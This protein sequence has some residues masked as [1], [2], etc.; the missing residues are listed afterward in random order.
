MD[1]RTHRHDCMALLALLSA[2]IY[3]TSTGPVEKKIDLKIVNN[4]LST[5]FN[6]CFGC[7]KEPSRGDGS[8]EYPQHM[9]WLRNKK[10]SCFFLAGGL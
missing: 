2:I 1:N 4:F 7:S 8:F 9:F 10:I 6:I 3:I 5:N